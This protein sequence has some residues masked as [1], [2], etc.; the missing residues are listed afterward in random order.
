MSGAKKTSRKTSKSVVKILPIRDHQTSGVS[1]RI[2]FSSNPNSERQNGSTDR[3]VS[4]KY[5]RDNWGIIT[6]EYPPCRAYIGISHEGGLVRGTSNYPLKYT[7]KVCRFRS[8][9]PSKKNN[10]IILV[11][12]GWAT[13]CP[14]PVPCTGNPHMFFLRW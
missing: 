1:S 2:C 4:V 8:G 10:G 7:C 12:S 6:H 5:S 13:R 14:G 11:V 9:S 3:S